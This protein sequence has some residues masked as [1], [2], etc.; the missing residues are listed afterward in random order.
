[1][2]RFKST[3][4]NKS[5]LIAAELLGAGHRP[6]EV[7]RKLSLRRETISRWKVNQDF[8]LAMNRAHLEVLSNIANDT[9]MLTNKAHQALLEALDD[10]EISKVA[11]ATIGIR[12][13]S[14]VGAQSNIYEKN[15][16]KRLELSRLSNNNEMVVKWFTDI[17]E[18][19]EKLIPSYGE[20]KHEELMNKAKKLIILSNQRP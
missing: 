13:L 1:M 14:L 6:S 17:L 19:I 15:N 10:K 9:T 8:V 20:V 5:Q 4:L 7:A 3:K 16:K 11:K 18:S 2:L 12:Y